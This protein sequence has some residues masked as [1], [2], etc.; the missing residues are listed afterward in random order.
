MGF[1]FI[2]L[3]NETKHHAKFFLAKR[4]LFSVLDFSL[5]RQ[6][7][8]KRASR[9]SHE[10]TKFCILDRTKLDSENFGILY[11]FELNTLLVTL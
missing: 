1:W 5:K 2:I 9:G 11:F 4:W 7:K 8:P 10:D 6:K 3:Q